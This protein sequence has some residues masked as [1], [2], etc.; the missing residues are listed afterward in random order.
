MR[1]V[2][3]ATLFP[4]RRETTDGEGLEGEEKEEVEN[5]KKKKK[6]KMK[7]MLTKNKRT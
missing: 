2:T 6:K 4:A 1:K 3:S 5:R 7:E